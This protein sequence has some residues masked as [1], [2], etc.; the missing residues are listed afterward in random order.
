MALNYGLQ[1]KNIPAGV[2][3]LSGY[4]LKSTPLTNYKKFPI[5]IMHG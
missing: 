3:A 5:S 2:I 4:M 1:A